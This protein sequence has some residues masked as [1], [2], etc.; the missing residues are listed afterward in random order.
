M[1]KRIVTISD[2]E[3]L[4]SHRY[5]ALYRA[6]KP[7][8]VERFLIDLME[9]ELV[10]PSQI[11]E[12]IVTMNSIVL[13]KEI[14]AGHQIEMK[15]TYPN[16]S[17][18]LERK[19]AVFSSIGTALLGRRVG[20]VVSWQIQGKSAEMEILRVTRQPEPVEYFYL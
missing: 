2:Y 6:K 19:I 16:E 11:P 14:G 3:R 8:I 17:N 13:L 4:M 1:E 20:H 10:D 15:L 18:E 12:G 9:A 5:Y 7:E